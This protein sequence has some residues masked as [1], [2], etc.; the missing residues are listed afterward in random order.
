MS[1]APLERLDRGPDAPAGETRGESGDA[2]P[3]AVDVAA[4][5]RAIVTEHRH[6]LILKTYNIASSKHCF[7]VNQ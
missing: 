4:L 7:V 6:D 1:Y 2:T 3:A 5:G